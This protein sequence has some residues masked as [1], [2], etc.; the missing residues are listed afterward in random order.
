MKQ[1]YF[2]SYDGTKLVR[3]EFDCQNPK[4]IVQIAH[5]M[6]EYSAT[7]FP[8]AQFLSDNGYKVVLFD[9]RGHGKSVKPEHL[10]MVNKEEKNQ[11]TMPSDYDLSLIRED[12]FRQTVA[13]HI[14]MTKILKNEYNLP[15]Y[16]IGHSYGSFIGQA[17]LEEC[18]DADKIVLIGSGY[19]KKPLIHIA[20]G[21][22]KIVK[23]FKGVDSKATLVETL[24]FKAYT[25]KFKNGSWV[26]SD[27][28]E[29]SKFYSDPLNATS[30]SSGFYSSMFT[31]QL[32]HPNT[33]ALK[34]VSK[35]RPVL[36]ASGQDD[37]IGDMGKGVKKLYEV[38]KQSGLNVSLKIYEN[39]RH[40][41]LQETN[42]Q[43]VFDDLLYFLNKNV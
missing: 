5:G 1:D 16:F 21:V 36:I 8:F 24:S 43:E 22:S 23:A 4:A 32:K 12:I 28:Q 10:G 42:K 40:A 34:K 7:Y 38:Y 13:D 26:T 41:I 20:K 33:S 9:Q 11:T 14:L 19:M 3:Y 18:P 35:S 2:I 25:K 27:I 39:M 15:V 31:N 17:Y 6:Q 29:T 30:F 37:V